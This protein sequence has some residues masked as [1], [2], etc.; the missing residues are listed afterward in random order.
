[1]KKL[2]TLLVSAMV[3]TA[4]F[5]TDYTDNLTVTVDGKAMPT[6]Q[7]TISVTE[8]TDGSYKFSLNNFKFMT[9]SLGDIVVDNIAG[10]T[11]NGVT[12]LKATQDVTLSLGTMPLCLMAEK[13]DGKPL[14]AD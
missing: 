12:S 13:T 14:C 8:N 3:A 6:I 11:N 10:T 5:A 7:S 9:F 2:F 4:S 1:M